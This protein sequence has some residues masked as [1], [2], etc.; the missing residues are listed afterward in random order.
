MK[1]HKLLAPVLTL[2]TLVTGI[3]IVPQEAKADIFCLPWETNCVVD[4]TVGSSQYYNVNIHNSTNRP[5]WVA[6]H[7]GANCHEL[8]GRSFCSK[9]VLWQTRGYWKIEPG[10][11]KTLVLAGKGSAVINRFIYFHAQ[12]DQG[13][14]W[15]RSNLSWIVPID[16]VLRPFFEADMGG[17]PS[18]YTQNFVLR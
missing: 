13:R 18:N 8:I 14:V 10:Q 6:V 3:F 2:S 12:D 1:F 15:G 11:P 7:Y 17:S 5:I 16:G 9:L 4:G